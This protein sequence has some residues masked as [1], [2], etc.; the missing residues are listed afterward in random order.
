MANNI[1]VDITRRIGVIA[2]EKNEWTKELNLVS[3]NGAEPKFD[4][5]SW[6][7]DHERMTRGI[8]LTHDE[9]AKIAELL[10]GAI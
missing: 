2:T 1:T 8:T 9:A 4:I 3:W 7:P 10:Q 6:S 5:R